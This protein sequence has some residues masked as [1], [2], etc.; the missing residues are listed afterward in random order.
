MLVSAVAAAAVAG[1]GGMPGAMQRMHAPQPER[2]E[3]SLSEMPV[4]D[5]YR[6]NCAVCHGDRRQGAIGPP[7]LPA[8]L[9]E[10]DDFYFDVI[11]NGRPGTAMPAWS[12]LGLGSGDIR[13]LISFLRT[14]P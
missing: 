14:E 8:T 11:A 12:A 13:A 5:F 7:L 4:G 6:A 3:G 1:C 2:I 10:D 9:T